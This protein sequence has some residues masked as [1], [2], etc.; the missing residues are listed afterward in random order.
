MNQP[1]LRDS[2][3]DCGTAVE[4]HEGETFC[5]ACFQQ[6]LFQIDAGFLDNYRRFGCRSHLVLAE[7]CLRAL[8]LDSPEHRKMLAMTI[9]EQYVQAT[10]D[11]AALVLAFRNRAQAPIVQ[12]FMEFQL[13]PDSALRFF[14][15]VRSL[16]DVELLAALDLPLPGDVA[17]LC[18][19]LDRKDAHQVDIALY[20]LLQDLRKATDQSE[21]AVLALAQFANQKTGAIVADND[22]WLNGAR[23]Q[24]TPN[25][26]ALL[27]LD[28]RRRSIYV[29]G[30]S[31][32]ENGMQS[33][34][35]AIDT[36]TR[37]ASNLIFAYL[38]TNDL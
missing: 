14:E 15:G 19:H 7:T 20:H 16:N 17:L 34:V 28:S 5:V 4:P 12:S 10:S 29:Q 3:S 37:A 35:D 23:S 1:I 24:L 11:L 18:P 31:A 21:E 38:Q 30:L 36:V 6:R 25:Q 32:D 33:V 22:R 2:C 9:F 26:V 27:V 13:T 8:V